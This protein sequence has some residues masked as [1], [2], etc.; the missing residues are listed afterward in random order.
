M[1]ILDSSEKLI[2]HYD[3]LSNIFT[4]GHSTPVHI[5]VGLT[6]YCNHKCPWCYIDF[7]RDTHITRINADI[8]KMMDALTDAKNM[9]LKAITIV[10]DGEP[11]L[12]PEFTEFLYKV[13]ELGL[14]IGLFTNGGYANSSINQA[15]VD[16]LTFVR[17]SVDAGT[18]E[19]HR[20]LH[21]ANDFDMVNNNIR[22]VVRMKKGSPTVGV[23]FAFNK[24]NAAEVLIA[25]K[26]YKD[27]GVDYIAYK[28]VYNN[29]L[30]RDFF[31][32]Q[33][34]AE[35]VRELLE[36]AKRTETEKFKVLWKDWQLDSLIYKQEE[37]R[38]YKVC[39]AIWLS[40]YIDEDGN[41]EFCG[42][43][44][45]RGFSI[46]NIY[47]TRFSE[48]WRGQQ[49][50]QKLQKID[51]KKCPPGCRLHGLNIKLDAIAGPDKE[52]HINFI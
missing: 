9:G 42:N 43:L 30:N 33:L 19:T 8:S 22:E 11:T 24:D 12:H 31:S 29:D 21:G 44:K 37:E 38:S 6:N 5:T 28:P 17:F 41:V 32:E 36:N 18:A 20:K 14:D 16:C 13:H 34:P 48:I 15:I 51:L 40:P 47:Q 39:R 7:I 2:H 45:G 27:A 49:H 52:D 26:L 25:A 35:K 50:L 10:G 23:Q 1:S 46:G 4:K 3:R